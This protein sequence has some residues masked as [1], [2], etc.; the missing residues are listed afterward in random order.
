MNGVG[1]VGRLIPA[2]FADRCFEPLNTLIPFAFVAG[3]LIYCWAAI[4][5]SGGLLA[6]DIV[7]GLFAAG[8]QSLFPA[9]LFSLTTD[10]KKAGQEWEWSSPSLALLV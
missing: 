10:L 4:S 5:S 7:Y 9:T 8:I 2:Y 1:M 6:F 3:L